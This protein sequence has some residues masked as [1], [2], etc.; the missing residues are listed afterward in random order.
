LMARSHLSRIHP[1]RTVD[2]PPVIGFIS[3]CGY[4]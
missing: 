2:L 4:P 3:T 1:G